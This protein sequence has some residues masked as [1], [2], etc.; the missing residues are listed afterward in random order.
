M[1]VATC[2]EDGTASLWNAKDGELLWTLEGHSGPV[3]AV[4]FSPDSTKLVTAS[5]DGIAQMWDVETGERSMWL[6]RHKDAVRSICWSSCGR[7][8]ATSVGK[9]AYTWP[10][11]MTHAKPLRPL[12]TF[13]G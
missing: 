12:Q 11:K 10:S 13:G 7:I 2:S 6:A 9:E 3:C 8:I 1:G 4:D 5:E